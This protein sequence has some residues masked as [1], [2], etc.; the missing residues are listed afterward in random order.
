MSFDDFKK[1]FQIECGVT[2]PD[3]S[4]GEE[5]LDEL[6]GWS[7]IMVLTL[8]KAVQQ[9]TGQ[10]VHLAHALTVR[11]VRDLY[12]ALMGMGDSK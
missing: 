12:D 10:K 11:T 6:A 4:T 8:A 7:S 5:Q 1:I 9:S 2:L 3:K